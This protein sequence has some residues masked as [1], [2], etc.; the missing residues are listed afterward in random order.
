M[1]DALF[2][3]ALLD[4]QRDFLELYYAYQTY[5]LEKDDEGLVEIIEAIVTHPWVKRYLGPKFNEPYVSRQGQRDQPRDG[6][7]IFL[8]KAKRKAQEE[9]Y[10]ETL[11]QQLWEM[12]RWSQKQ[13]QENKNKR[14]LMEYLP[15]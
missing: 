14:P 9:Y 4:K 6:R 2:N 15:I 10:T 8:L 1:N 7:E 11:R 13:N 12:R 5:P 3:D